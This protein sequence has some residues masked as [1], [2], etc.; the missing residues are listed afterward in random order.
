MSNLK[1]FSQAIA[2]AA[3]HREQERQAHSDVLRE[4]GALNFVHDEDPELRKMGFG[5]GWFLIEGRVLAYRHMANG[6]EMHPMINLDAEFVKEL[7]KKL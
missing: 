7:A 1:K 5:V 6:Y 3:A 4:T 2:F